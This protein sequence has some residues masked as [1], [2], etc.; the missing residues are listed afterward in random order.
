[1][2]ANGVQLEVREGEHWVVV[3]VK[4]ELDIT[5]TED[6]AAALARA[7]HSQQ[8]LVVVDL[9]ALQFIDS[10]G[11]A[12]LIKAQREAQDMGRRFVVVRGPRQIQQLLELTG[13][14]ERLELV[15]SLDELP[16][17]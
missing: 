4:G 11:L 10:S 7:N 17:P 16:L 2:A 9:S 14:A 3:A 15:D 8:Q 12:V 6:F 5:S 1:M 13:L